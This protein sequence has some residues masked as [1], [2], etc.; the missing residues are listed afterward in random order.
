MLRRSVENDLLSYCAEEGIGVV[1]YSPLQNGLLTGKFTKERIRNLPDDDF[2]KVINRSFQEPEVDINLGFVES[3]KP[4]AEQH[5]RTLAQLA[6]AWVLR[7]QEVTSAITG[8]RKPEQIKETAAAGDW[9]LDE[10]LASQIEELLTKRDEE[11]ERI[12][13]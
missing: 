11:L 9:Y 7:R 10:E 1:A 4:L 6:L 5:D 3:L 13:D 8:T 2:R 12:K